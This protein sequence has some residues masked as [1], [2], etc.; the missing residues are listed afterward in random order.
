MQVI[1]HSCA[2]TMESESDK[3]YLQKNGGYVKEVH[4]SDR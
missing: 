3:T 1:N 4:G 2:P